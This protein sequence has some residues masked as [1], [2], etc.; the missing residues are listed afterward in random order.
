MG[1]RKGIAVT[2]NVANMLLVPGSANCWSTGIFTLTQSSLGFPE[3]EPEKEKPSCES[4]AAVW[5]K[6]FRTLQESEVRVG[7]PFGEKAKIGNI[8]SSYNQ[9]IELLQWDWLIRTSNTKLCRW[10]TW[11]TV[12]L[13]CTQSFLGVEINL[14]RFACSCCS[15]DCFFVFGWL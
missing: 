6:M 10:E 2:F 11:N 8:S 7:R 13:Y 4:E 15:D 1:E 9:G 14:F 5:R 3:D 12:R